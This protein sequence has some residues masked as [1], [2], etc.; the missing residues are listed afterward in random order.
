MIFAPYNPAQCAYAPCLAYSLFR[1]SVRLNTGA[2][3]ERVARLMLTDVVQ[4]AAHVHEC[5][6]GRGS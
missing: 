1:L 2:T 6:G 4:G 5:R 3:R